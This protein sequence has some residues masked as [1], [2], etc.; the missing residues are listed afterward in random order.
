VIAYRIRALEVGVISLAL[1][2]P[3]LAQDSAAG[4]A[5]TSRPEL[6]AYR[7][8]RPPVIDGALDDE[9]WTQPAMATSEWLSYNPLNGD[10]IPQ[11]TRTWVAY[12]DNYF[13]FAFKCD[14]PEPARIKTSIA[15]RDNVWNDDWV[16]LSLDALGTGQL[17]YHMMVNPSGIQM[18]MLNSVAAGEDQAPD[19]I[20]D[21]A[22]RL[23]DTGY[24]VEIR[25]PLQ[26]IRFTAGQ[27]VRMGILFWRRVSRIGVSV[28]WP[29][30]DAGTWVFEKNASLLVPDIRPRPPRDLIP[31]AT[32]ATNQDRDTPNHWGSRY[33]TG[34]LGL[35]A[36]IGLGSTVT[37]DA[38]VNPDFSQV[39]SDAFQVQVNQR[40]PV[41]F[42][43]KRP[44]F[45]EGAGIFTLA[46]SQSGDESLY[47]AVNTRNIVNPIAGAK[48]TGNAGALTFA[49]LTAVDE[50]AGPSIAPGDSGFGRNRTFNVGRVEYSLKPGSY[51]GAIVTDTEQPGAFN[52]VAGADLSLKPTPN[53]SVKLFALQSI[54][55]RPGQDG[56]VSGVGGQAR[57]N[58]ESKRWAF[59]SH[60][61]HYGTG[62]QMD[63]AFL[64]RVGDTN[65]WLYG[66]V[67]F[68]PDKA[69]W[70]WL[71]RIQPFTFNQATHDVIQRGDEFFM[72]QGLRLFFT[73]SGFFRFD[74]VTGH[75][76]FAGQ[77]FKINRWRLQS[78]AQLYRWLSVYANANAGAATFYDPVTP[79][80]GRSSDL[81]TGFTFQPSGRFS[82]TIDFKRVAF[83]RESTGERVYTIHILN[84]KTAYQFTSHF[85]LR[86]IAQ[87]DSSRSQVLT[88]FLSSYELR[89]GT[90]FF[91][92][93][94]S[95]IERRD[96]RNEAWQAGAGRYQTVRRGL[97]LKASY[98]Y[99][100]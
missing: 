66:E 54:S 32:F 33:Q 45:M 69:K 38:T 79:Y 2:A 74:Q 68:Y 61:E 73:R 91:A 59:G 18:D 14:D 41:F 53:Q 56:S 94:G 95:L 80:Q 64:N 90:V 81:S 63:T 12:D 5:T 83:D 19:W 25:L 57:Y 42:P 11:Q 100:F 36:K 16:G 20:W 22:G 43:E 50:E 47:S 44:F 71:R 97:F 15:R 67:N 65:A 30:L 34:G 27:N 6:R 84:T 82:E 78:S 40:F 13:Y 48:I 72:L 31:T 60:L 62:F 88:D 52:R 37:L 17:S 86:A 85:F 9:A 46:G 70:P 35:S 1:C 4:K 89:P 92:G 3:L 96:Y 8:S 49:T 93:W 21:S 98:L 29:P 76:P 39:E 58:Y 55:H 28:A 26:S 10:R 99:R 87:F 51:V 24:T 7:V 77:R 75:E 23:T